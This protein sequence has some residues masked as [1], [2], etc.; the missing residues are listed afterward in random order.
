MS[1]APDTGINDQT[2]RNSESGALVL[3]ARFH[4]RQQGHGVAIRPGPPPEQ[5]EPVRRPARIAIRLAL[6]HKIEQAIREGKIRDRADV[7]RRLGL[8]RARITQ[9]CDLTLLPVAEQERLLFLEA[10]DGREPTREHQ[11][12]TIQP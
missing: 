12:R 7:A 11:L 8:T 1:K 6:A 9:I 3:K 10:V 2:S 5:R 4:R